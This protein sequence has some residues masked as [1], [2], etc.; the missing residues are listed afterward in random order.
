MVLKDSGARR[1]FDTGAVRDIADGKGRCDLL[2]QYEV[3][4]MFSSDPKNNMLEAN[5]NL[6]L[7]LF[8]KYVDTGDQNN[9]YIIIEHFIEY[10]WKTDKCTALLEVAKQYEDGAKKY[11][12]RNWQKGIPLHCYIDSGIRH[13]LKYVRGD[14]DEPHERA[15]IWNMLGLL[16][17]QNNFENNEEICDLPF[18]KLK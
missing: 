2:P 15:F 3:A 11:S 1:K 10:I 17:T 5:I 12:E 16:W 9:I 8:D 13:M 6:I 7:R 18:T 14:K 4:K